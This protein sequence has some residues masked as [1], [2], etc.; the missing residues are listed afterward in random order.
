MA[1]RAE[2]QYK[3]CM[4][5]SQRLTQIET[6]LKFLQEDT[7]ARQEKK[8]DAITNI[9]KNGLSSK[10]AD[11]DKKLD[12]HLIQHSRPK[13]EDGDLVERRADPPIM[14]VE[15]KKRFWK[16]W[17]TAT[18]IGVVTFVVLNFPLLYKWGQAIIINFVDIVK[19]LAATPK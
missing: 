10:V 13:D 8:L 14:S 15:V 1:S 12:D 18:K 7:L 6:T 2:E 9:L 4:D 19:A 16:D 17:N 5:H 3:L 11:I